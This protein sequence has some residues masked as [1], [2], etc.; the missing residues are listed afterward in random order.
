M[1]SSNIGPY[2]IVE[3]LGEGGMGEVYRALDTMLEREVA[4]KSLHRF[5]TQDTSRLERFRSEAVTLAKLNHPNIAIL[6][7]FFEV[8]GDY[9]MVMEYVEGETFEDLLRRLGA[10][11]LRQ[12]LELFC[13][14]LRGFEH[15][16]ARKVIH[17]DIKPGN[18]ML[19]AERTVKITDFGIARVMGTGRLTQTGKLIGTLEY[20]SPEQVQG[21][22]QDAR[23]DIYSLGILLYEMVTGHVPFSSTSDFEIMKSHLEAR[24][25]TP[26]EFVGD[27]PAEVEGAIQ[28]ALEKEPARRFQAASEFRA[29]L[30]PV[31]ERLPR[32]AAPIAAQLR[33]TRMADAIGADAVNAPSPGPQLSDT[34]ARPPQTGPDAARGT[35]STPVAARR[36]LPLPSGLSSKVAVGGG[37]ALLLAVLL[38]TATVRARRPSPESLP[39]D[40]TA[41]EV[42]NG[43]QSVTPIPVETPTPQNAATVIAPPMP[44]GGS[45]GP[46]SAITPM[47]LSLKPTPNLHAAEA[48]AEARKAKRLVDEIDE[49]ALRLQ[50]LK[51]KGR[52][53]ANV[54]SIEKSKL[55]QKS[56]LALK[57]SERALSLDKTNETAWVQKASTLFLTSHYAE[58]G[59]VI[60]QGLKR[61]PENVDL[62][63]L[64]KKC[65]MILSK[66]IS[67]DAEEGQEDEETDEEDEGAST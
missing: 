37:V 12:A 61:F 57:H 23:S 64:Q 40:N 43:A 62:L 44:D 1:L 39:Q 67:Q 29:V 28:R 36:T 59:K 11:P 9:Y 42:R 25:R 54:E 27:L 21:A 32:V 66:Q 13:Q 6:H 7:N 55:R 58:A 56:K 30:E 15:A 38:V 53:P 19:T 34:D 2:R 22:E 18:L 17:R 35:A 49:G 48:E 45:S 50:Q 24:P 31:L 41:P 3:K 8:N 16:H 60:A 10:L 4:I 26:R 33:P 51:A 47:P 14:A 65:K 5:L 52:L 46:A 20:M 63:D